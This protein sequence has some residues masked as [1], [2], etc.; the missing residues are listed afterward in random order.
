ML[1]AI[2]HG[3]HEVSI[4]LHVLV[5]LNTCLY[6]AS[7]SSEQPS[8]IMSFI[9]VLSYWSTDLSKLLAALFS[10]SFCCDAFILEFNILL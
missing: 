4:A 6:E 5:P 3:V 8:C 2:C 10:V 1:F 9:I 7:P